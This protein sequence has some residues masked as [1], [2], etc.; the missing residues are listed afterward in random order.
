MIASNSIIVILERINVMRRF[1]LLELLIVIIIIAIL[2]SLL[3]PSLRKAKEKARRVVCA[4]NQSQLYKSVIMYSNGM[5]RKLPGITGGRWNGLSNPYDTYVLWKPGE[6]IKKNLYAAE[7][8]LNIMYCPSQSEGRHT[9]KFYLKNGKYN[10]RRDHYARS[11]YLLNPYFDSSTTTRYEYEYNYQLEVGK[12]FISDMFLTDDEDAHSGFYGVIQGDGSYRGVVSN[13]VKTA[14]E[15]TGNA[16]NN[17]TRAKLIT[18]EL[19][20]G[21]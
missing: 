5:N 21:L 10:L 17:W 3:L 16:R 15:T 12:V 2:M 7:S 8:N 9:Y 18:D 13:W 11:G 6:G 14:L 1:T 19:E 4:S 20:N